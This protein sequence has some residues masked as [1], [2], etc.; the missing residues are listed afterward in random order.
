MEK[1]MS[2]ELIGESLPRDS[3]PNIT[4]FQ[5]YCLP[6]Q[7]NVCPSGAWL[8]VERETRPTG[9]LSGHFRP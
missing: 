7:G 9:S 3:L 2:K 5:G 4:V 1:R 6:S 8:C